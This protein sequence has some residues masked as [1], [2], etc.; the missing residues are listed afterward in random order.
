MKDRILPKPP[1][2]R[3]IRNGLVESPPNVDDYLNRDKAYDPNKVTISWGDD[4]LT[5]DTSKPVEITSTRKCVEF[6]ATIKGFGKLT[7]DLY[8]DGET[9]ERYMEYLK[10]KA[11][12]V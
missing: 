10:T 8:L 9:Y 11:V 6:S 5:A 4:I 1:P 3:V 2:V 7:G 12:E